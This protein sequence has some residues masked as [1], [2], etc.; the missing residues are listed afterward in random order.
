MTAVEAE[1]TTKADEIRHR[2]E[3]LIVAGR[4]P[5]GSVLRQDD[6]ARRFDVSRTPIREALRHLAALGL[7]SFTPN[8]GVRVLPLD[9]SDWE[10]TYR[11]R[12]AL[13]G[14]ATEV[15]VERMTPEAMAEILRAHEE[16]TRQSNLLRDPDL[17]E[18]DRGAA[19]YRWV[20]ANAWFHNAIVH[21]ADMP[22]FDRIISGLR[23]V[24]SGEANWT[25]GSAADRLYDAD[26]RHHRAIVAA[27]EAG[28]PTAARQLM[29]SHI[30][31][32]WRLLTEVLDEAK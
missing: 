11:A 13:E 20:E 10:Q 23:R 26:L 1:P 2:L 12:A 29:E 21:A 7:V 3:E 24:F 4:L 5:S 32:S 18:D 30:L 17:G 28:N 22:V 15:A 25:P 6:L 16:F 14:S 9:R 19:S 27:I 8:R 31:E